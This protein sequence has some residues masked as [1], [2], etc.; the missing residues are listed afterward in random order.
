MGEDQEVEVRAPVR[1]KADAVSVPEMGVCGI[2]VM[3]YR[4]REVHTVSLLLGNSSSQTW[5]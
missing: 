4:R 5:W 3:A 1:W 2:R